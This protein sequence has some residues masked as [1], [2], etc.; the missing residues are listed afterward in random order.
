MVLRGKDDLGNKI[1][2]CMSH[3]ADGQG[4]FVFTTIH[5]NLDENASVLTLTPYAVKF[6]EESGKLSNDFKP[7]GKEFTIDLT[8]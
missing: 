8:K 2:F 7:V 6:P 5:G 3:E 4:I 1:E